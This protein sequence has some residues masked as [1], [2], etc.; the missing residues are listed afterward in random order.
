MK[1]YT[2]GAFVDKTEAVSICQAGC[3][4]IG[5]LESLQQEAHVRI[6]LHVA[7]IQHRMAQNVLLS[8]FRIQTLLH[9][10]STMLTRSEALKNFGY[11]NP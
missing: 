8:A 10:V 5:V 7:Y 6:M 1:L 9:A 3:T 2:T 4:T 11:G